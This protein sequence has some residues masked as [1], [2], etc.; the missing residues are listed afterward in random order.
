[1]RVDTAGVDRQALAALA[2]RAVSRE[3]L[4]EQGYLP[5][6]KS[7]DLFRVGYS[8]VF[9]VRVGVPGSELLEYKPRLS[10]LPRLTVSD[11]ATQMEVHRAL[12]LSRV[13]PGCPWV[14]YGP[15]QRGLFD[16]EMG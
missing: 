5:V 9:W 3:R 4:Q 7:G 6:A 10:D 11:Y 1:M 14:D 8:V 15:G 16:G 13:P 12:G 2:L